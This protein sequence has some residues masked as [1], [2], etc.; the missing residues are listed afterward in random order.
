MASPGSTASVTAT[1]QLNG[2]DSTANAAA[3]LASTVMTTAR[4]WTRW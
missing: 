1:A 3:A 2:L 4:A